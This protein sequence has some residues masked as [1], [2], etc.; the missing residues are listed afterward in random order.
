MAV[1]FSA[2]GVVYNNAPYPV[3]WNNWAK[4]D[5]T[6]KNIDAGT[7]FI[8]SFLADGNYEPGVANG[9]NKVMSTYQS[10]TTSL[11]YTTN[12]GNR[13]WYSLY[14]DK[15][16]VQDSFIVY[17]VRAYVTSEVT[18]IQQTIEL[19]PTS[20]SL[21]QNYPN[22]FNPSTVIS[23]SLPKISNVQ[24]KIYDALGREIRSLINEEKSSGTYNIL[25]DGT[26]NYGSRVSSGVYFYTI[27]AGDFYQSKKMVLLK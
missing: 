22:P 6:D 21:S 19:L 12:S 11:T 9:P 20:Y 3:P 17:L 24:I 25:W 13:N 16:A 4:V 10:S 1:P 18:G 5:L 14:V 7:P 23:Y 15:D 2:S 26:D 8:V 27:H